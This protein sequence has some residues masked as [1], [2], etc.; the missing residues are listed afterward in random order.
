MKAIVL[1]NVYNVFWSCSPSD[2]MSNKS[3]FVSRVKRI[4]YFPNRKISLAFYC[5]VLQ[6]CSSLDPLLHWELLSCYGGQSLQTQYHC[7]L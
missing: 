6:V 5:I 2:V 1:Y 4:L 7:S 3:G